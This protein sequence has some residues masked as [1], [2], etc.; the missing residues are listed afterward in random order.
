MKFYV[1]FC[2]SSIALCSNALFASDCANL[3]HKT[4][5][6]DADLVFTQNGCESWTSQQYFRGQPVG[7]AVTTVFSKAW[8]LQN[9]DD[10]YE[11]SSWKSRI[12]WSNDK[13]ILIHDFEHET[14]DKTRKVDTFG[15]M[16]V[17]YSNGGETILR[18]GT[19][20]DRREKEDGSVDIES[21]TINE[22][23]QK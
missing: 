4:K 22:S 20:F 3:S 16:S 7:S 19:S 13:Q 12:Y 21:E 8:N 6:G 5:L 15:A 18:K 1:S 23:L 17:T 2:I 11:K 9:V 14:F 10:D